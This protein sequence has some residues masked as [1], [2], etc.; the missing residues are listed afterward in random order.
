MTYI[1]ENN[2]S[3]EEIDLGLPDTVYLES[4]RLVQELVPQNIRVK[5]H[6]SKVKIREDSF[7][8]DWLF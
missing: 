6:T 5:L 8:E 7:T 2:G 1:L 3:L 4:A